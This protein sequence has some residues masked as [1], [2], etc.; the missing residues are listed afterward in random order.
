MTVIVVG[1]VLDELAEGIAARGIDVERMNVGAARRAVSGRQR[2]SD[3]QY[4]WVEWPREPDDEARAR[5]QLFEAADLLRLPIGLV[6]RSPD[7]SVVSV[8]MRHRCVHQALDAANPAVAGAVDAMCERIEQARSA[9]PSLFMIGSRLPM[10]GDRTGYERERAVSLHSVRMRAF[11]FDQLGVAVRSMR[12]ASPHVRLPWIPRG[13]DQDSVEP[14]GQE[15]GGRQP[16]MPHLTDVIR[17]HDQEPSIHLLHPD[18]PAD[19]PWRDRPPPHLLITGA[20]GTGKSLVA[21]LV[22]RELARDTSNPRSP[23]DPPLVHVNCGSLGDNFEHLMMGAVH[24]VFTDV[25]THLGYCVQA[26]YGTLFLDE[27]ADLPPTAQAQ[28]LTFLDSMRA[29]PT[30]M[31]PFPTF[32]RVIAATNKDLDY[33]VSMN[34]FK[35][36]LLARFALR[37]ELPSL[38]ERGTE[39]IAGLIDFAAQNPHVNPI[40]GDRRLVTGFTHEAMD[41]LV[42]HDYSLGNFRELEQIVADAITECSEAWVRDRPRRRHPDRSEPGPAARPMGSCGEGGRRR[43]GR[44]EGP[45]GQELARPRRRSADPRTADPCRQR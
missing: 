20:S 31:A 5:T 16:P 21:R 35:H 7:A 29:S 38:S 25:Q 4:L 6:F 14:N 45:E 10:P 18:L 41:R 40:E 28:L 43:G 24:G 30:G 11:V 15:V 12:R 33:R 13:A 44:G 34:L 39:E 32:A 19:D 27:V 9:L 3:I 37:V 22:H 2:R 23:V 42:S 26:S 36:D 1:D 8:P 17:Q